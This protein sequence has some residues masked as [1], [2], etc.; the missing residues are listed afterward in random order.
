MVGQR[1]YAAPLLEANGIRSF[2]TVSGRR[3]G[4]AR[5]LRA[6]GKV[7]RKGGMEMVS[8]LG[9]SSKGLNLKAVKIQIHQMTFLYLKT[10]PKKAQTHSR[11]HLKDMLRLR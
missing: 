10:Q 11:S 6:E 1:E 2:A 7:G 3:N 9:P 5:M 8:I 4:N